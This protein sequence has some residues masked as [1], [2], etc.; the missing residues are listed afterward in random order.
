MKQKILITSDFFP[1]AQKA[2][3]P[4]R[5]IEA[6]AEAFSRCHEVTVVTRGSDFRA[7]KPLVGVLLDQLN[8]RNGYEVFYTSEKIN[9]W[10]RHWQLWKKIKPDHL[11]LNSFFSPSYSLIWL[12]FA[13]FSKTK[14]HCA[15]RGELMP[16]ALQVKPAKKKILLALTYWYWKKYVSFIFS[17]VIELQ[18]AQAR[19]GL[20]SQQTSVLPELRLDLQSR[21][22]PTDKKSGEL[23]LIFLARIHPIKNL[24]LALH[25]I[26]QV[27][28]VTLNIYGALND[29]GAESYWQACL[30]E[31]RRL[32][33]SS[34][35]FYHG[36]AESTQ[37]SVLIQAHHA[38]LMPSSSEN[39][40]HSILEALALGRPVLISDRTPWTA[41]NE[42]GGGAALALADERKFVETLQKW[43]LWDQA[44]FDHECERAAHF[45]ERNYSQAQN[46][47]AFEEFQNKL[48]NK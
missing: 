8:E 10:Q 7:H 43:S 18:E 24:H 30:A 38:L 45:C 2:G 36:F 40:G 13:I 12:A 11:I 9:I 33:L 28:A 32:D 35:V 4:L 37:T 16:E 3:G 44:Q 46:Q 14:V 20:T 23:K 22:E 19:L 25:W 47:L 5:T 29:S 17:S 42:Q 26:A 34:R 31:I 39:F 48:G 6:L 15:P 21:A 27:P 1:P 41:V